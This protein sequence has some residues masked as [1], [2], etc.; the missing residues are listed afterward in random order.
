[1]QE[2]KKRYGTEIEMAWW[3]TSGNKPH[4][5]YENDKYGMEWKVNGDYDK[6]YTKLM[7]ATW[8]YCLDAQCKWMK[9]SCD[10]N[11]ME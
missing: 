5:E 8:N 6:I 9:E 1:M 2:S 7:I 10:G 4:V 3:L 11:L